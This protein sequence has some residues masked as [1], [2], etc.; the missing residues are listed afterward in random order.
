MRHL[1]TLMATT[2]VTAVLLAPTAEAGPLETRVGNQYLTVGMHLQPGF[3]RD[4]TVPAGSDWNTTA[5]TTSG[6]VRFGFQHVLTLPFTMSAELDLG[7]VW[8]DEHTLSSTGAADS[9]YALAVRVG[10]TG[11][12]YFLEE[13]EGPSLGFG[14]HARWD[15]LADATYN[16]FAPHLRLGWTWWQL[17]R[18]LQLEIGY[19]TPAIAGLS[20]PTD[21]TGEGPETAPQDGRVHR[22]SLGFNVGF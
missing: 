9:G 12:W 8:F 14:I 7:T 20:L 15:M 10:L 2:L 4:A 18:W 11:R 17:D 3:V 22:F 1:L 5:A 19:T 13:A 16:S 21:F 6:M